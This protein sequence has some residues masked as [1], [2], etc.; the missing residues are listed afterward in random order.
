MG[1]A[2]TP[3]PY[4]PSWHLRG[5]LYPFI[6]MGSISPAGTVQSSTD[7]QLHPGTSI[8]RFGGVWVPR[9]PTKSENPR[10]IDRPRK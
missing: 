4:M 8:P 5:Q 3:P 10:I 2:I 6:F 1:G 7:S 9:L